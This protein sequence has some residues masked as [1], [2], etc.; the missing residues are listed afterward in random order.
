M[1]I[2]VCKGET[3]EI[4]SSEENIEGN[5]GQGFNRQNTNVSIVEVKMVKTKPI[6][7]RLGLRDED[8]VVV[9]GYAEGFSGLM[10][11]ILIG[12]IISHING[13][14]VHSIAQSAQLIKDVHP[15]DLL[16]LTIVRDDSQTLAYIEEELMSLRGS[17]HT[18]KVVASEL[19]SKLDFT[20]KMVAAA[21]EL[22]TV[23]DDQEE[24]G[25]EHNGGVE[26]AN[27]SGKVG[28]NSC[29]NWNAHLMDPSARL[30]NGEPGGLQAPPPRKRRK[31]RKST[32][33]PQLQSKIA[34]KQPAPI[35]QSNWNQMISSMQKQQNQQSMNPW[36]S[37]WMQQMSKFQQPQSSQQQQPSCNM[38]SMQQFMQ[39][40]GQMGNMF[41]NLSNMGAMG[42]M[43]NPNALSQMLGMG[44][45]MGGMNG[46]NFFMKGNQDDDD[47][48]DDDEEG[49]EEDDDE[50]SSEESPQQNINMM[51]NFPMMPKMPDFAQHFQ[52]MMNM[53]RPARTEMFV[54]NT[55][56][57]M[58][59][60]QESVKETPQ[61]QN[62][63][64]MGM[65]PRLNDP[66]SN[67]TTKNP[68]NFHKVPLQQWK[69]P[70]LPTTNS[71][72]GQPKRTESGGINN[73][74]KAMKKVPSSTSL[75]SQLS[76]ESNITNSSATSGSDAN[77]FLNMFPKPPSLP[78]H[79]LGMGPTSSASMQNLFSSNSKPTEP[80]ALTSEVVKN[81]ANHADASFLFKDV[82]KTGTS[83]ENRNNG[84]S[85]M[86]K[87]ESAT[88]GKKFHKTGVGTKAASLCTSCGHSKMPGSN[89]ADVCKC[90]S[91]SL[92][93]KGNANVNDDADSSWVQEIMTPQHTASKRNAVSKS[94]KRTEVL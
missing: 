87:S 65:M 93:S 86:V 80:S 25:E 23:D 29:A 52:D 16:T 81:L 64:S 39:Q 13:S 79:S 36:G 15:G 2:H 56:H 94:E 28:A 46:A 19:Q 92:S 40:M 67:S 32:T 17:V 84:T 21:R 73:L 82:Y 11:K 26:G 85:V 41:P 20:L 62:M 6:G 75:T 54:P 48:D 24:E 42:N 78:T 35:Q 66:E 38:N 61:Q 3:P 12:D 50:G 89:K 45:M 10:H 72:A 1:E 63:S 88:S 77:S 27:P 59:H 57:E 47:D 60:A 90:Q 83:A 51:P 69:P 49:E 18:V 43:F 4:T 22:K 71:R 76:S 37:N 14:S 55:Q 5:Q 7:L 8:Q 68:S 74:L 30:T 58:L 44:G 34:C 33:S 31:R 70:P 9:V 53:P 91:S